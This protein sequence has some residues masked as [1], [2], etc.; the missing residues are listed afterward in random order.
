M[1]MT[2]VDDRETI[3]SRSTYKQNYY[4]FQTA[5]A[6]CIAALCCHN[7]MQKHCDFIV[8][9]KRERGPRYL[10]QK[11]RETYGNPYVAAHN[12]PLQRIRYTDSEMCE[13]WTSYY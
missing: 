13:T 8:K 12:P 11:Y 5:R 6:V 7:L 10:F 2:I 3:V 9:E 4:C 1:K